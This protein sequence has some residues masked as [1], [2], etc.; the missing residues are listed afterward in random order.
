MGFASWLRYCSNI[1][2]PRPTKLCVMFGRLLGWYT[3]YTF[4]GALAPNRILPAA[5]FTLR[6]LSCIGSVTARHLSSGCQPNFVAWYKEWNYGTFAEAATYIWLGRW[7]KKR[8][9]HT[10]PFYKNYACWSYRKYSLYTIANISFE[11]QCFTD[12]WNLPEAFLTLEWHEPIIFPHQYIF[13]MQSFYS[14]KSLYET[15][16]LSS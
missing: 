11:S 14:I 1:A 6:A 3:I 12:I 10:T 13:S 7:T 9:N 8:I 15:Q 5:K 4:L 2:H 16:R